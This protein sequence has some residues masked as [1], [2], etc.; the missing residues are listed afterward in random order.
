[1]EIRR[2]SYFLRIAED[3]SLT[4]ASGVLNIAQP[5]LSRQMRLLEEELGVSLFSRTARGML[6]TKEGEYLRDA[7]AGPLREIQMALQSIQSQGRA[8]HISLTLGIPPSLT[9]LLAMPIVDA[10]TTEHGNVSLRIVEGLAGSM[11]DWLNRGV[12]DFAFLEEAPANDKLSVERIATLPLVLA[13]PASAVTPPTDELSINRVLQLPLVVPTHHLGIRAVINDMAASAGI[14]A[15][16]RFETDSTRLIADLVAYGT[17][18]A[19]M[20]EVYLR[21][22]YTGHPLKFWPLLLPTPCLDLYCAARANSRIVGGQFNAV[23]DTVKRM[24][25]HHLNAEQSDIGTRQI[26]E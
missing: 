8:A 23:F 19:L 4:K 9:Q 15:N 24:A 2:L 22:D 10:V 6:L 7:V 17:G 20:P 25:A 18:Y 12:I 16:I 1:M 21:R 14:P 13:G 26:T 5:A 3:G 11:I